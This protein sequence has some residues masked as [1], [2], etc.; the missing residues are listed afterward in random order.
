MANVIVSAVAALK[1]M[2]VGTPELKLEK[3]G[4]VN[5]YSLASGSTPLAE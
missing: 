3:S 5:V 4:R 2:S 1:V